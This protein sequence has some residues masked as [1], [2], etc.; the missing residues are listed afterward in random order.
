MGTPAVAQPHVAPAL[1]EALAV[2]GVRLWVSAAGHAG[3]V[4][5]VRLH[6]QHVF[7]AVVRLLLVATAS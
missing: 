3:D 5:T 2:L 4:C 7:R 6:R 1:L